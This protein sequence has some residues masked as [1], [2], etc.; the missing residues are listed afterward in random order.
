[1]CVKSGLF[2]TE[3]KFAHTVAASGFKACDILYTLCASVYAKPGI[4]LPSGPF[5]LAEA[6]EWVV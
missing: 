4:S 1:M 6:V 5:D 2:S 3:N